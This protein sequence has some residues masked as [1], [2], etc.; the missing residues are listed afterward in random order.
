ML[1]R[2]LQTKRQII[3]E[4]NKRLLVE[5]EISKKSIANSLKIMLEHLTEREF[6]LNHVKKA[7][8]ELIKKNKEDDN[9][10]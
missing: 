2:A 3:E 4:A 10:F 5:K 6:N 9:I 7:V 1:L 8:N